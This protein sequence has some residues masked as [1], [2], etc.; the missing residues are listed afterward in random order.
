MSGLS[1]RGVTASHGRHVVLRDVDLDVPRGSTTAILGPS[2]CG[3]TTLL[4]VVAGFHR[5]DAGL[6]TIGG[7]AVCGPGL[8]TPPERRGIGY[9]AQEGALFP[10]LS[11]AENIG[12]GLPRR[13]PGRTARIE[14]LL[15][16]V[17]LDLAMGA[18]RP[19]QLSGGQQQRVALA[20]ALARE[21]DLVLLDEPFSA[22]DTGLRAS[23]R[24]AV[25]DAL[26]AQ[27]VTVLLVTH[28]QDEALSFADQV[29]VMDSGRVLQAGP[30]AELYATP[31]DRLTAAFLG[32][33]STLPGTASEGVVECALG[34]LPL[35]TACSGPVEV[36]LRPEQIRLTRGPV[37]GTDR[38]PAK[39][40]H[41]DYFG[42]DALVHLVL[43]ADTPVL[44]RTV[45]A[46]DLPSPG[47]VVSLDVLGPVLAFPS[48]S[49]RAAVR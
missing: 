44:A 21:P 45:A 46:A 30:P 42:H 35:V 28:D 33:V 9:L 25:A 16:L 23:T 4:R 17:G 13:A 18:R 7:T 10:H 32:E 19:D 12:F 31:A 14:Q 29:V 11:V 24:R 37:A 48:G 43:G 26:A 20:R 8:D 3:K 39:V 40:T 47:E 27:G 2:G 5:A 41:V 22:L 15:L 1:L 38:S 6:V 49:A 36:S 34:R